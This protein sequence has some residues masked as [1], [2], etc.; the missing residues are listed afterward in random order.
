MTML[1]SLN[2]LQASYQ[3]CGCVIQQANKASHVMTNLPRIRLY[4]YY[5]LQKFKRADIYNFTL[6]SRTKNYVKISI[7]LFVTVNMTTLRC[8]WF[9]SMGA[10]HLR[11]DTI[12]TLSLT[13]H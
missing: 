11:V 8:S 3:K 12:H 7:T 5:S 13:I 1:L 4:I 6:I 9:E 2:G 10:I